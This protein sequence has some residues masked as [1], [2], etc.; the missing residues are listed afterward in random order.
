MHGDDMDLDLDC[1]LLALTWPLSSTHFFLSNPKTL[2]VPPSPA[3]RCQAPEVLL[4][5]PYNT[6]ADIFRWA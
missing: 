5:K 2:N 4:C 1:R 3:T 6:S